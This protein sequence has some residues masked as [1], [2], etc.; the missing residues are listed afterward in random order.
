MELR[1][2]DRHIVALNVLLGLILAYFGVAAARDVVALTRTTVNSPVQSRRARVAKE[3]AADQSRAAYQAIV[4]RDIFNL[5][6]PPAAPAP[7]VVEDLHLTLV[8]VSQASKGKPYAI[9][10]DERGEQAVYRVGEIIPDS[11][12]LL[13]VDK[14]RAIVEHGGKQVVLE[15]PKEAL[16]DGSQGFED[17]QPGVQPGGTLLNGAL[18]RRREFSGSDA[19]AHS[20]GRM[21]RR[22]SAHRE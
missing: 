10:A 21:G 12:K 1:L 8:G 7:V 20:H 17:S 15:F 19:A 5:V 6:P 22:F 13:E 11:G 3:V 9:V 16:N 4:D 2:S 14:D 18:Y